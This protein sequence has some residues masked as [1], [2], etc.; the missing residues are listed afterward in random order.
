[1][2]NIQLKVDVNN[3]KETLGDFYG[4]FF[5]DL[6]HAADGGLYGELIQNRSFEFDPIDHP[7]YHSLMAWEKVADDL[8]RVEMFVSSGNGLNENNPHYLI[9]DVFE[10]GRE[11]GVRNLGFQPGIPIMEEEYNFSFFARCDGRPLTIEV[12]LEDESG[13]SFGKELILVNSKEWTKYTKS[14]KVTGQEIEGRL[15]IRVLEEGRLYLD[16]VSLFPKNTFK[17]RENG[18]RKDIANLLSD[19]R[20]KFM[21]FPG[22]CLVHDGSI[23]SNDRDSM[24]RW[25]NTIGNLEERPAR[26]NNWRYNQTLGLGYYEYF[27]FCEDIG[28]KPLPV[29]PAGYDPHHQRLVPFEQLDEWIEDALD[30]IEFAKGD[31]NTKWGKIRADLGH[32]ETFNLEYLGIGNEE[33]GDGF[34]ERYPYFHKAI[35]EKYPEIKIINSSG[36]F[37]AGSE[38][39]RGWK[40]ARDNKSDLVDE[41]YYQAPEW[42]IANHHH[43]DN[44]KKEDPKV[45]LGEY[46][47][48]GNTWYNAL[49]EASYM[50]GLERNAHAVQL[51][52]YAP[53][54]CNV[55]YINWQPDMI[56]FNNHEVYG[57]ANYYVQKLFMNH[58]GDVNI[59]ISG[60][61]MPEN[62]IL[63]NMLGVNMELPAVVGTDISYEDI[64]VVDLDTGEEKVF[65]NCTILRDSDSVSLGEIPYKNYKLSLKAKKLAGRRGFIIQFN[66]KDNENKLCFELGGWQNMD[67]VITEDISGRNTC[68]TESIFSVITN[69]VYDLELKVEDRHIQS[70]VDGL[71]VNDTYKSLVEIEPLYYTASLE[72][73]TGDLIIKVVNL[74]ENDVKA[75]INIL[76]SSKDELNGRVYYMSGY[77]LEDKNSFENPTL[78]SP[79]E[80]DIKVTNKEFTYEFKKESLTIIRLEL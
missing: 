65:S 1:M 75:D 13:K 27:T 74:K 67:A 68:L 29:L 37:S 79:K 49:S 32:K 45:F 51:A 54:L 61:N 24:Y 52:C 10:V 9:V 50:I 72:E 53:L 43:Y 15:V 40:S 47:S 76:N 80:E 44:F 55:N 5:E 26:R 3:K 69:K 20:P 58:Q 6:N 73:A 4:I 7:T 18:M 14:I 21:R 34:F 17:N 63:P 56:W 23:N 59:D 48:W 25:K 78:V 60:N 12:S 41:H 36:P 35:R 22:G 31:E 77:K 19:M 2:G 39:D 70:F 38:Y 64:K 57:T 46:A 8:S 30:L 66:K 11:A 28:A 71:L 42:F 62:V 33:V 16:M